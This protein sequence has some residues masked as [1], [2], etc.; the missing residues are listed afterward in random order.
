MSKFINYEP[1]HVDEIDYSK[2]KWLYN[3]VCCND[4]S[5]YVAGYPS[6][7]I[8]ESKKYCKYFEKE[9]RTIESE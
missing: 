7:K 2:C 9:D 1:M 6:S 5:D 8:C 4:K 3:E